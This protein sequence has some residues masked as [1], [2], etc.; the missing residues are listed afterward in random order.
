[1]RAPKG[2]AWPLQLEV[3][4]V[5]T[6]LSDGC[7]VEL[8]CVGGLRE[9]ERDGGYVSYH[10]VTG[11]S[12]EQQSRTGL[13]MLKYPR[14]CFN[15]S[16]F[17]W[18]AGLFLFDTLSGAARRKWSN[19]FNSFSLGSSIDGGFSVEFQANTIPLVNHALFLMPVLAPPPTGKQ[20]SSN[21]VTSTPRNI[22]AA[23]PTL[24]RYVTG[25]VLASLANRRRFP[26]EKK[27]DHASS[28][29]A[30][31]LRRHLRLPLPFAPGWR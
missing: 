12:V 10:G 15:V 23:T 21:R 6:M 7:R 27:H 3:A 20:L 2:R 5:D 25:K 19:F 24:A 8:E 28:G 29:A 22:P 14:D 26:K 9:R 13:C 11:G 31:T 4:E 30:G 18:K 1:M 16:H 17:P